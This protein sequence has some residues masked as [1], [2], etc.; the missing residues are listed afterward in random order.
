M[1]Q[2]GERD[3][4]YKTGVE[5]VENKQDVVKYTKTI[6]KY[7]RVRGMRIDGRKYTRTR[8]IS[9]LQDPWRGDVERGRTEGQQGEGETMMEEK[10]GLIERYIRVAMA[11]RHDS[12]NN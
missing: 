4:L 10:K 12:H 2:C 1:G 9:P 11:A 5:Y 8:V 6:R 3:T 7:C